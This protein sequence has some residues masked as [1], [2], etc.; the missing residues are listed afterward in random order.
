VARSLWVK[1]TGSF[2][3][4]GVVIEVPADS[5]GFV[6]GVYLT[7]HVCPGTSVCVP[8]GTPVLRAKV[9]FVD[10]DPTAPVPGR[11]QVIVLSWS[12]GAG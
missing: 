8:G 5:P 1:L 12:P 10:D 2:S 6:F 4:T 9:A 7:A 11:R 3:Y